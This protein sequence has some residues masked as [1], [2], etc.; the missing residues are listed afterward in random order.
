VRRGDQRRGH[1]GAVAFAQQGDEISTGRA[2]RRAGQRHPQDLAHPLVAIELDQ[3]IRG[4]ECEADEA[5]ALVLGDLARFAEPEHVP[6]PS[7]AEPRSSI[8]RR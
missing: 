5:I 8:D 2:F 1:H 7:M 3:C 6:A 4:G